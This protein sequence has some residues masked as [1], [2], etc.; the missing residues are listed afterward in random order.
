[1]TK[2]ILL[3]LLLLTAF[4]LTGIYVLNTQDY[5]FNVFP[6]VLDEVVNETEMVNIIVTLNITYHSE[7]DLTAEEKIIQRSRIK[8]AR[9]V[10]LNDFVTG[11]YEIY[12]TYETFPA[13]AIKVNANLLEKLKQH[14][15]VKNVQED[16][17]VSFN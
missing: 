17:S 2:K 7:A 16:T 6:H 13:F 15:L 9:E 10:V 8:S 3:I 14:P 12:K 4:F 11:T 1:M 5:L